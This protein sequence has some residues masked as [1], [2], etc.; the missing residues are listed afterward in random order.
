MRN[1][2]QRR[3]LAHP[4]QSLLNRLL[5]T[6]INI[7]RRL[8][9]NQH[10]RRID[11]YPRQ[12][13]QLF[14]ANGEVIP[15]LAQLRINPVFHFTG[16]ICQLDRFQRLPNLLF[17]DVATESNVGIEGIRQHHRILLHHRN[18]LTQRAVA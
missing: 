10:L 9:K 15:L 17:A 3:V 1:H 2:H 13:Q 6:G 16:Q 4:G 18:P 7:G 5:G 14:L 12:R 11:Q 8:I